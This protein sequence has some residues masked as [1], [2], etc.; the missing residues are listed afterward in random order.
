MSEATTPATTESRNRIRVFVNDQP[1]FAPEPTM[2]GAEI[3]AMAG[4]PA[5]NHLFLEV[6]G[7]GD[8]R[9]IGPEEPIELRSGMKFYD[10]PVGTFG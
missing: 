10:V 6:P 9:P 4:L 3:L 8:D 1:F 5:G 2:T 7:P